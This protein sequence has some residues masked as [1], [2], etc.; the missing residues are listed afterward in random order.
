[1]A[2]YKILSK[3]DSDMSVNRIAQLQREKILNDISKRQYNKKTVQLEKSLN[4]FFYGK[5]GTDYKKYY[6]KA[7]QLAEEAFDE[8]YKKHFSL[9]MDNLS[10]KFTA[11][12]LQFINQ[13]KFNKLNTAQQTDMILQTIADIENTI[14]SMGINNTKITETLNRIKSVQNQSLWSDAKDINGIIASLL[15]GNKTVYGDAFEMPLAAFS[16]LIDNGIEATTADLMQRVTGAERSKSTLNIAGIDKKS[17]TAL[18]INR[19]HIINDGLTLEYNNPTQDK[20]DVV[21]KF[22]GQSYNLSAKSYTSVYNNIHILGGTPL[23]APVLN[24]SLVDFVSHYLTQLYYDNGILDDLHSAMRLNIL[25]MALAGAGQS[26]AQA[27][28]FV[29][30][31][32]T[33]KKIYVRNIADI[34]TTI[35]HENKWQ[36]MLINDIP[37]GPIPDQP[38]RSFK[39]KQSKNPIVDM[40]SAMHQIKLY[41]SLKGTAVRDAAQT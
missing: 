25:F 41:V 26:A 19:T 14:F 10:A 20:V 32:K 1:M 22:K 18:K 31:D 12:K 7:A 11:G 6:A 8:K 2:V 33:N 13:K 30:N 29:L 16:A 37:G 17:R 5:Q 38:L 21:L 35:V 27:D 23:T 39:W 24:L 40:I 36:S 3:S 34:I 28:T 4:N 9:S 15:F